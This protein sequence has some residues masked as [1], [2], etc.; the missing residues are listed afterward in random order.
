MKQIINGTVSKKIWG[1]E[2]SYLTVE[3]QVDPYIFKSM[4]RVKVTV[5]QL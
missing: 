4:E 3:V 1:P 2:D 5:E